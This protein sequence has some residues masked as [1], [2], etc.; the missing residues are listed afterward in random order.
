MNCRLMLCFVSR[1]SV[2]VS[3]SSKLAIKSVSK[4]LTDVEVK[5]ELSKHGTVKDF[6]RQNESVHVTYANADEAQG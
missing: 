5:E 3:S 4:E 2:K 1:N 6:S